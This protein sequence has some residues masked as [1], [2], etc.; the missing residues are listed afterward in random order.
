MHCPFP[1]NHSVGAP[2][3]AAI[4][5]PQML[6]LWRPSRSRVPGRGLGTRTALRSQGGGREV[7]WDGWMGEVLSSTRE[8]QRESMLGTQLR[9]GFGIIVMPPVG[10]YHS[11]A[12]NHTQPGEGPGKRETKWRRGTAGSSCFSRAFL[13]GPI[14][15]EDSA[16][17]LCSA[18]NRVQDPPP[19]ARPFPSCMLLHGNSPTSQ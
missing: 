2:V 6:D 17:R 19:R 8:Q 9:R 7:G 18:T 3:P 16:Q 10:G 15:F 5:H 4:H 11:L 1:G 12:S 14:S 13:Q